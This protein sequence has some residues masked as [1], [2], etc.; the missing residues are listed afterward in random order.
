LRTS[1]HRSLQ[2]QPLGGPLATALLLAAAAWLAQGA[3]GEARAQASAGEQG[4]RHHTAWHAYEQEA[5]A[6]W[7][8]IA[9]KRSI[10]NAKRRNG[11]RVLP[12][13]YVLQQ[14]P[15][16]AGP[17]RPPGPAAPPRPAIPVVADFLRHAAEQFGFVPRRPP[18][19]LAF[20][21][22]YARAAVEAGLTREQVVGLYV[23]ET[24]GNGA[25]DTQ[26]GFP[27][28]GRPA[29]SPALGYNQLLSTTTIGLV[30]EHGDRL[31]EM[32]EERALGAQG[33]QEMQQKIAALRRMVAFSRSVPFQWSEHDRLAKT[34]PGGMGIQA[35]L[36][37]LDLGPW[38]QARKLAES[39]GYARSRGFHG[40]LTP[41]ELQ[42]MNLTGP[43]NGL[44]MVM[45]PPDLRRHVPTAN[46]FQQAGYERNPVARRTAGGS[47]L[48]AYI[49]ERMER[50]A[51]A[52]GARI[53]AAAFGELSAA[54]G[55]R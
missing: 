20:K 29:I 14:P 26:A 7:S 46:F 33:Q 24:G 23:L 3:V 40:T 19:E 41:A 42:L 18:N 25:H 50:G 15:I 13:D 36:L 47:G 11:E 22:A 32:L 31:L 55:Q 6:Y 54:G 5:A 52:E 28:P 51:G 2:R 49:E 1:L 45:M 43:G 39:V 27:G 37:D 53:L 17:P 9:E 35:V 10:R 34:T 12:E 16:Y 4:V 38:L 48:I 44:D 21:R 30:A 8:A